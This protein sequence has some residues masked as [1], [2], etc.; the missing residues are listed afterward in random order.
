MSRFR[1]STMQW[2]PR[3]GLV[4][5]MALSVSTARADEPAAEQPAAP[6][7]GA[8]R[9]EWIAERLAK[10]TESG[11]TRDDALEELVAADQD[12][13]CADPLIALLP[14]NKKNIST[15]WALV[16]ALGHNGLDSAALPIAELLKHKDATIVANAAVSLEYIGSSDK[17]VIAALRRLA[18]R[19]KDEATANHAYRALGRCGREDAKV[20]TLLLKQASSAKSEFASYGACMGLAYFEGDDKAMRGVEKVLKLIGVP[21]SRRGGGQNAVKRGLVSWTL[22]CIGD[23]KS[24]DFM[25]EELI[26][27]LKNVKAFWVDGLRS[28]WGTVA[29][30]CDGAKERL[31]EVEAGVGGFVQFSM[32]GNL[33][34]YGAEVRPLMDE[35]RTGREAGDFEPK[36]DGL[37]DVGDE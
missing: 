12:G 35:A 24:A 34:R 8:A 18:D 30:V 10:V 28:F 33:E 26:D 15:L 4:L 16:R 29:D 1:S 3:L 36:G 14:E 21:G 9:A 11:K 7:E 25:R 6:A 19:T 32:R 17:K 13:D 31:P 23:T 2:I 27:R 5:A 37:L 22:A 20:R